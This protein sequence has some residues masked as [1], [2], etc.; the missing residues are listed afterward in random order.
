MLSNS[1]RTVQL[2]RGFKEF[3][4]LGNP[5]MQNS[6]AVTRSGVPPRTAALPHKE[7]KHRNKRGTKKERGREMVKRKEER[8]SAKGGAREMVPRGTLIRNNNNYCDEDN[9]CCR[10]LDTWPTG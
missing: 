5:E 9:K 8:R 1:R 2:V 4:G 3:G 7:I 10:L 6:N